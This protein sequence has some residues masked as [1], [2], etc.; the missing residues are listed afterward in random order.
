VIGSAR[1]VSEGKR[2]KSVRH[3][4]RR[5]CAGEWGLIAAPRQFVRCRAMKRRASDVVGVPAYD[6][7]CVKTQKSRV[8]RGIVCSWNRRFAI[9]RERSSRLSQV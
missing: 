9:S 4:P 3:S 6:P 5:Y 1:P 8:L 7:G 2:T